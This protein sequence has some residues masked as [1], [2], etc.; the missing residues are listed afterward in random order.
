MAFEHPRPDN[1]HNAPYVTHIPA[2]IRFLET[3][4]GY[5]EDVLKKESGAKKQ[6]ADF[7]TAFTVVVR[8]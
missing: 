4:D 6:V 7:V 3:D 8:I 5:A 2:I 1:Q